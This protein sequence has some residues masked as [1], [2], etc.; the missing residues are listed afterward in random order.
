MHSER[1]LEISDV[2]QLASVSL[3]DTRGSFRKILKDYEPKI[4][5]ASVK[6]QE[7]FLSESIIGSIRGMHLQVN[8]P[9]NFRLVTVIKGVVLD[10]LLDLRP[11]SPSYL[12]H[13]MIEL[14]DEN[15]ISILIPPGIAHGFQAQKNAT[16]LYISGSKWDPKS[17]VGVNPISFGAKWPIPATEIS[18]R[19]LHLPNLNEFVASSR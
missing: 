2:L 8:D 4:F 5:P 10:C 6:I 17:D 12:Q 3:L 16:M 9:E 7:V 14:S 1:V 18:N 13:Q 11:G 19:D 15:N